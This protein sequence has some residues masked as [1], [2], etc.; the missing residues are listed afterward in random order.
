MLCTIFV[1]K[2]EFKCIIGILDY[3]RTKAQKVIV[4]LEIL[5]D[6]DCGFIDYAKVAK[7]VKKSIKKEKFFL[8]E[9]AHRYLQKK[10][11][12]KFPQM[13]MLKIKI[14]K[15]SIMPDCRVAVATSIHFDS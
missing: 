4:D 15:P 9:D 11:K 14:T 12:K 2:L 6:D 13:E 5:Y 3:E 8:I 7:A 10:L 1:E